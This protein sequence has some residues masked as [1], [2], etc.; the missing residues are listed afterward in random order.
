MKTIEKTLAVLLIVLSTSLSYGRIS[1]PNK[2]EVT[3]RDYG[4]VQIHYSGQHEDAVKLLVKNSDGQVVLS[5]SV[6]SR[7]GFF[8]HYDF[9]NI[10]AGDYTIEI[11]DKDGKTQ[12]DFHFVRKSYA[13]LVKQTDT[14]YRLIYDHLNK[15][16]VTVMFFDETG[17]L[18][19]KEKFAS[20]DGF[21]KVYIVDNKLT[22][23]TKMRLVSDYD[24]AEYNL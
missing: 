14:R 15:T 11:I 20:F 3:E 6:D 18:I 8:M 10:G 5:E 13:K 4:L 2:I 24:V 1:D 9:K 12:K 21:S 7:N 16:K 22:S 23:A 17:K 19:H